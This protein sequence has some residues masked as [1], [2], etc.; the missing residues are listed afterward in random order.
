MSASAPAR[1]S[2]WFPVWRDAGAGRDA[3]DPRAP[4]DPAGGGR[5]LKSALCVHDDAGLVVVKV[6]EGGEERRGGSGLCAPPK[7]DNPTLL[8]HQVYQK[9]PDSGPLKEIEAA[10]L[11]D[12]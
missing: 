3:A 12:R 5:V 9:R 2:A 7:N 8:P 11:R 1:V 6:C 10:L 4:P